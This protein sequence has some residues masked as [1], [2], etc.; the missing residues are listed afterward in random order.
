MS[1]VG[2]QATLLRAARGSGLSFAQEGSQFDRSMADGPCGLSSP[3]NHEW[4]QP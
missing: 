3:P 1:D 4:S 2:V